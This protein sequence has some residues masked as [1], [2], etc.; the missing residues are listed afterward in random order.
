MF[1]FFN[2]ENIFQICMDM[3]SEIYF[4]KSLS[5]GVNSNCSLFY[6][7]SCEKFYVFV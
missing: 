2:L 4:E 7:D 3:I 5:G 6:A 1:L